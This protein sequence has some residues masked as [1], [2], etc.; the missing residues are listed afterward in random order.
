MEI[1]SISRI[2]R[3]TS[4]KYS[5][6]HLFTAAFMGLCLRII[7]RTRTGDD[8]FLHFFRHIAIMKPEIYVVENVPGMR[9][10][11]VVMEAMSKLPDYY[12]SIFCPVNASI[13][14]PQDRERLILIGSKKSFNWR[15]P[16]A[17][18]RIQL[19]EILESEPDVKIPNYVYSRLK[20]KYR[21]KPI[22]SDP[23]SGDIAP[24]CVAHY[25]KDRSTRLVKDDRYPEGVRPY[26]V[27]EYARLQGVPDWF[28]FAGC[29]SKQY[30][31]IGNGVPVHLGRWLGKEIKRYFA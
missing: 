16:A 21:D 12:V 10:F 17:G 30:E 18:R 7:T 24:C 13:W 27:R 9:K 20:G 2:S 25:S 14:L 26:T 4:L 19:K 8:L 15:E 29:Q 6:R 22:I 1:L 3:A 28:R 5:N 11:P 31:M 23:G